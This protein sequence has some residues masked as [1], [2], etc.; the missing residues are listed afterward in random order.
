[1]ADRLIGLAVGGGFVKAKVLGSHGRA[2]EGEESTAF[3]DAV[4]DGL[5]EVL[6]VKNFSPGG[7]WFVGSEDHGTLVSMS[8]VDD[9]EEHIGGVGTVSQVTDL[10]DDEESGVGV[11]RES[12]A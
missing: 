11:G 12:L 4:D 6:V 9:V 10:V 7:G 8:V 3:E 2:V 1:M 5:S